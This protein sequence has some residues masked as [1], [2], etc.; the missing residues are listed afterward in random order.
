MK[1]KFLGCC[2]FMMFALLAPSAAHAQSI[3]TDGVCEN[4]L[5]TDNCLQ[6]PMYAQS[7][8]QIF[9]SSFGSVTQ[10]VLSIPGQVPTSLPILFNNG[11]Q[12]NVCL[13]IP[14]GTDVLNATLT[15]EGSNNSSI[16]IENILPFSD[17]PSSVRN[18]VSLGF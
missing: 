4:D 5:T 11:T 9:G 18:C 12:I 10:V 16:V 7:F 8:L 17:A 2:M 3:G 13:A 1:L 6:N 15:V 14:A